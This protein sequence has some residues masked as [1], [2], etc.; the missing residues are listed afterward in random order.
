MGQNASTHWEGFP[1]PR[2]MMREWPTTTLR[3]YWEIHPGRLRN[4]PRPERFPEDEALGKSV[5][6]MY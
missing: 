1:D 4:F 6:V 3:R 2:T 5:L